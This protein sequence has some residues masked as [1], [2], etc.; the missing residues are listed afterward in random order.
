VDNGLR[1]VINAVPGAFTHSVVA[2]AGHL[3]STGAA[4]YQVDNEAQGTS[5]SPHSI[6]HSCLLSHILVLRILLAFRSRWSY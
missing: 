5:Y 4:C 2:T 3:A 1:P 6:S